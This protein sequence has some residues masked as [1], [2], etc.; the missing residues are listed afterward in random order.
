MSYLKSAIKCI[1]ILFMTGGLLLFMPP[2]TFSM[3][4]APLNGDRMALG[5]ILPLSGPYEEFG[6]RILD[7]L[8]LAGGFFDAKREA[9]VELYL[10]D[11]QMKPEKARRA[12]SELADHRHVLAVIGPTSSEESY[13]AAEE[14]EKRG[15]PLITLTR[16][17]DITGVG[18]YIFNALPSTRN[19]MRHLVRYALIQKRMNK[20]AVFYPDVPAGR[21]SAE[22]FRDEMKKRGEKTT[23]FMSYAANNADHSAEIEILTGQKTT[24]THVVKIPQQIPFEALFIPDSVPQVSRIVSQ[25]VS[26]HVTGFQLLSYGGWNMPDEVMTHRDLF[27]GSIF[28]DGYFPHG[29]ILESAEFADYFY[30]AYDREADS[31]DAYVYDAMAMT[32]KI[33]GAAKGPTRDRLRRDLAGM[34]GYR[35]VRGVVTVNPLRI[36]DSQPFLITVREGEFMQII[37]P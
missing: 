10:E 18:R 29:A 13:A 36:M 35:G 37:E 21:D 30:E 20:I 33:I 9:P 17:Q 28:V 16:N 25:L 34:S 26:Y 27:E 19:Q 5:A 24:D 3:E 8:L 1:T 2:G 6:D 4:P 14:A 11:A 31:L 7:S 15:I 22:F 12:L 32:L 23:R